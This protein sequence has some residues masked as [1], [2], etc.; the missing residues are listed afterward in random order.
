VNEDTD[1]DE[2]PE[3]DECDYTE[4]YREWDREEAW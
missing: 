1:L 4:H 3:D 2:Q